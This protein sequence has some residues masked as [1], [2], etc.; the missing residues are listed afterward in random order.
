MSNDIDAARQTYA[1][2]LRAIEASARWQKQEATQAESDYSQTT[3]SAETARKQAEEVATK[4]RVEGTKRANEIRTVV[5]D[6]AKRGED[7][8]AR[9]DLGKN[10]PQSLPV[11][12]R[13]FSAL[14]P[15]QA[16][17]GVLD[18]ATLAYNNLQAKLAE[19]DHARRDNFLQTRRLII[20]GAILIAVALVLILVFAVRG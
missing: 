11:P 7:L 15:Q 6:T 18:K 4:M 8:Y 5:E 3:Q 9:A 19:L 13:P 14:S 2:V 20:A 10:R 1:A 16:L 12:R 17:Q